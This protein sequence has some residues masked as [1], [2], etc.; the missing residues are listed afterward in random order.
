MLLKLFQA[1]DKE[2]ARSG[3][4]ISEGDMLLNGVQPCPLRETHGER[5]F[6]PSE[7]YPVWTMEA[8]S[9]SL[10]QI[11][12]IC[13]GWQSVPRPSEQGNALTS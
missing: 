12:H 5:V 1:A 4:I 13:T 11:L 10:K 8:A 3:L 6:H 9:D 2:E 7:F